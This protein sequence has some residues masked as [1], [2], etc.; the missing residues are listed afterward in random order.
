MYYTYILCIF[1]Y[2]YSGEFYQEIDEQGNVHRMTDLDGN[3]IEPIGSYG[4]EVINPNPPRPSWADS[5]VNP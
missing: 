4:A 3:T 5:I 1:T 2:G